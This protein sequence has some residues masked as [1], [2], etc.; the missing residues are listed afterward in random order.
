MS[1]FVSATEDV[2][3]VRDTFQHL[4]KMAVPMVAANEPALGALT[5]IAV[6][7]EL[8]PTLMYGCML[9]PG[10]TGRRECRTACCGDCATWSWVSRMRCWPGSRLR[11]LSIR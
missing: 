3:D 11:R 9:L 6:F 10:R 1:P 4:D 7:P 2:W 8:D 5:W